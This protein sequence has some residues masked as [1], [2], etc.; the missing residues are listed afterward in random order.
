MD[1]AQL[2]HSLTEQFP[3]LQNRSELETRF[4]ASY[5]N[6]R[7]SDFVYELLKIHKNIKLEG[8]EEKLLDHIISRLEPQ[9]LDYVEVRHPQTTFS[10]LQLIDKYEER[11]QNRMIRGPSHDFRNATHS[12]N[13]Q[14]TNRNRQENWQDTRVNNRYHDTSRPQRESNRF[15]GQGV[16]DNRR[17]D[18]RRRSG[19]S[20]HGFNNHG[21]RQDGSRNGSFRSQNGKNRIIKDNVYK[22]NKELFRETEFGWIAGGRLQGTN[23]NN[24]SC[25][26]LKD[27]DSVEDTLRQGFVPL[28]IPHLLYGTFLKIKNIL[29]C[30]KIA[31]HRSAVST[32]HH[33]GFP[34]HRSLS[35]SPPF[36]PFLLCPCQILLF[37]SSLVR[38]VARCRQ[39]FLTVLLTTPSDKKECRVTTS[40]RIVF[41]AASH[42]ANELSLNDCLWPG[43][44][45]NPNLLDVLINFR[46]NRVA[47]SSDIRQAFLQICLADKQRFCTVFMDR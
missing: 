6:Q 1:Y 7:P 24:F 22:V 27:N 2:K 33:P 42:Q 17:Y 45:L 32:F 18:S 35:L 15:G 13:N 5:Q 8:A 30:Y 23:T 41:D 16:G 28:F 10:L 21:G 46:L 26:F 38:P 29:R 36:R 3:V 44:N 20:D 39:R 4:Y 11:F 19:Q 34:R 31:I 9:L 40:T 43:P 47:I 14:F 37:I 12:A 25:Y